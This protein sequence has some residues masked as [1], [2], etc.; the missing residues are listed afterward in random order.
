MSKLVNTV[1]GLVDKMDQDNFNSEFYKNYIKL[2]KKY[3]ELIRLGIT[4][5]RESHIAGVLERQ[6]T[7][8]ENYNQTKTP[9][10]QY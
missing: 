4:K 9:V 8:S 10:C 1:L 3:E 5:K 7:D 2:S 6:L